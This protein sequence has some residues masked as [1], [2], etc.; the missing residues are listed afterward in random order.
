MAIVLKHIEFEHLEARL[1][2]S[3]GVAASMKTVSGAGTAAIASNLRQTRQAGQAL[4]TL[5]FGDATSEASHGL[6]S[7]SSQ[8]LSPAASRAMATIARRCRRTVRWGAQVNRRRS[9]A[10]LLS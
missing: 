5:V 3:A 4:D 8:T 9:A 10:M 6:A 1:L 2:L 7:T